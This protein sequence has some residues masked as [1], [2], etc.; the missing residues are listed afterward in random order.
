MET[1]KILI[2]G[3]F[4]GLILIS[5]AATRAAEIGITVVTPARTSRAIA[6]VPGAVEVITGSQLE[7]APGATLNDKLVNII[8]GAA[9]SR[10]NGIYSFTS[11]VTLRGLPSNEQGRTLILLDGVPVNTGAT[12]SVNWNRLAGMNI[13]R[14]EIFKGPVS[15]LYGSNAA[16][17]VINIITKKA[18]SGYRLGAAYG[19]YNTFQANA[20][21]GAKIKSLTLSMDGGYLSSEIPNQPTTD[22]TKA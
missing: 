3:M 4:S 14:I 5:T 16:A 7:S 1:K 19:T 10:A 21:A 11:V 6:D 13:D 17:G 9:S 15:S 18:V 2:G 22:P 12:G 20:G 8:P